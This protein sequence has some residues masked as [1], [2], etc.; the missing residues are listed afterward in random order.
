M[1]GQNLN[2]ILATPLLSTVMYALGK[3]LLKFWSLIIPPGLYLPH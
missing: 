3:V 1:F 2:L